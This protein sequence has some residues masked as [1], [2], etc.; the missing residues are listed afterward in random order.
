MRNPAQPSTLGKSNQ[1]D[2]E[3]GWRLDTDDPNMYSDQGDD[4]RARKRNWP[5]RN[6]PIYFLLYEE[7]KKRVRLPAPT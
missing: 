1:G 4:H 7:G 3:N 2:E 6:V 5:V